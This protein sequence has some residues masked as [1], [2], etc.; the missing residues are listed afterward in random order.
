VGR[1]IGDRVAAGDALAELH[2]AGEDAGAVE[3]ARACFTVADAPAEP[4]PLVLERV[5]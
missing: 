4:P 2:L 5:D 1:R 3:R